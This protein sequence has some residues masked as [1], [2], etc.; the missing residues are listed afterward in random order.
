MTAQNS[1][2][3][4]TTVAVSDGGT[5]STTTARTGPAR[6]GT[7]LAALGVTAFSLTFPA[8]AWGLEGFGPWSLVAVRSVLA[9]LVAGAAL[10][11]LRIPVPARRHWAGLAVV[12]GGVV[13]G[14][15]MLTTLALRTSTTSHAAVV[16]GLLPLTTAALSALRTGAR[17]SRAFWAAALAGAAVVIAFTVQQSGGALSTGDLFLFGALLVCAAGY[18]E[19]GRLAREMPGWQVI[20]WALVLCLPLAV[21]V[22]A[23]ALSFEP[24]RFT[25]HSVAGLLWVAIGS[26]FLGLV[27]WYRGMAEIGVSKASQIQLAQP[28]LTLVWS[29]SLLGEHLS[30]AAPLAAVGVLVCIA[31]TQRA[32]T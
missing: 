20:G 22:A 24:V 2:T 11:V 25:A 23:L 5:G 21:P 29:V 26:Q 7:L 16:V 9:A 17:P 32:R 3:H 30:P 6:G 28:L 12:G 1:A 13:L 14:F 27:V 15:P 18:T 10:L 8:T 4:A 19:G 31:V